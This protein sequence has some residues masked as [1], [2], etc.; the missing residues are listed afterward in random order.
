MKMSQ[1]GAAVVQE[2]GYQTDRQ[3]DRRTWWS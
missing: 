1:V 2:D 3:T